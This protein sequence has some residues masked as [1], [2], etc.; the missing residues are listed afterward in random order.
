MENLPIL[1]S[2]MGVQTNP[3]H[4]RPSRPHDRT[5]LHLLLSASSFWQTFLCYPLCSPSEHLLSKPVK[6]NVF[7][8]IFLL[9]G[10][11]VTILVLKN[12]C[13]I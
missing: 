2:K 8:C 3:A 10:I 5:A 6:I 9:S 7:I 12:A 11:L 13:F 4:R 1:S